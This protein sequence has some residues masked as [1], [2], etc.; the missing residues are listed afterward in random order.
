MIF[1]K[2]NIINSLDCIL[3]HSINFKDGRLKKG[4]IITKKDIHI[5][6]DSK[7]DEILVGIIEKDDVTE[8]IAANKIAELILGKNIY[9]KQAFTGR[10][11]LY[12]KYD[13]VLEISEKVVNKINSI[14]ESITIATLPNWS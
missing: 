5:L 12:S 10:S 8:N 13:G 2:T 6:T 14:N 9:K 4:K 3:A 11:N 1:K 7:I